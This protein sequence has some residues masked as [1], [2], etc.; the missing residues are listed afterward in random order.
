MIYGF[1]GGHYVRQSH[2]PTPTANSIPG[3]VLSLNA[4]VIKAGSRPRV[5]IAKFTRGSSSIHFA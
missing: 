3:L 1:Y 4:K 2:R 5:E